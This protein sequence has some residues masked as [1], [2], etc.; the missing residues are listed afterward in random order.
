MT[1]DHKDPND[2]LLLTLGSAWFWESKGKLYFWDVDNTNYVWSPEEKHWVETTM[3][4][5]S[6]YWYDGVSPDTEIS[7]DDVEQSYPGS[8]PIVILTTKKKAARRARIIREYRKA[9]TDKQVFENPVRLP[10]GYG[11]TDT[12]KSRHFKHKTDPDAH[13]TASVYFEPGP[14]YRGSYSN[15]V[16][17][18]G[19]R[20]QKW[21]VRSFEDKNEAQVWVI[22]GLRKLV[23]AE[24]AA[25]KALNAN[26]EGEKNG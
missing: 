19:P 18:G 25:A 11:F 5:Y 8:V 6:D 7:I 15:E 26:E 12:S 10:R 1:K 9:N 14:S 16:L 13:P 21:D 23:K 20:G 22:A 3:F 24:R 4:N 17:A 2:S